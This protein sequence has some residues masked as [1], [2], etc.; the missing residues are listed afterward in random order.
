MNKNKVIC[1]V[2]PTASGKTGLGIELAKKINGEVISADS[3]QI[4]RN[5]NIGTA[6]VTEE[7]AQGIKHHI[8]DICDV[9][10]KFSVADFKSMCYDKIEEIINKGK[11]PIIVGGTGLYVSSVVDNMN[12][13]EIDIDL[14][15]RKKLE[16]L[17]KTK[18][19]DYIYNM[20][21]ET[22]PES[23]KD[24]HKNN[25]KRVIR[26][27]EIA[28]NSSKLKSEHMEEENIRKETQDSKYDFSIFCIEWPRELL[29]ERINKRV[30]IMAKDGLVDEARYVYDLNLDNECTCMQAIGYKEF[31]PYFRCE[32]SLNEC[33]E[34]LKQETRKYA[35]RQMT[36]FNNKLSCIYLNGQD[37]KE[38][39]VNKII[40]NI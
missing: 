1:I 33:I 12:F 19:S 11:T 27:L 35:K 8:I 10:E 5:L 13:E 20:L 31:F 16:E 30:D 32:K 34:K 38:S 29:Y 39:L 14:E 24:I 17:A 18:G 37:D 9:N 25:V 4:Y 23:C 28:K 3:M 21:L 22:D 40:E 26:A 15:Y 7:E 36:W 2:G 6:K